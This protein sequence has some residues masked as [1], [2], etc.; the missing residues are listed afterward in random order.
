MAKFRIYECYSRHYKQQILLF[1]AAFLKRNPLTSR[2]L[3]VLKEGPQFEQNIRFF[4][5]FVV[6]SFHCNE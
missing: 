5:L 3:R 1:I 2:G 6:V 4:F